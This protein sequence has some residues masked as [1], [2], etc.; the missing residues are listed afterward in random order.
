MGAALRPD[1][2]PI[3]APPPD[4]R[5]GVFETLL[6][7]DGEPVELEAHLER[8]A[9]STGELFGEEPPPGTPDLV[10]E[11]ARPLELG[12]LRLDLVPG[13]EGRLAATVKVAPVDAALVFPPWERAITL[14]AIVVHGGLGAHK[15]S[16]RRLLDQ[17]QRDCGEVLPLL[18]DGDGTVLEVSRGNVFLVRDGA[19]VTPVTDGRLLPGVARRRIVEAAGAAGFRVDEEVVSEDGLRD[20]DEVF[21]SGSV[22]GIE[23][24]REYESVRRWEEGPVTPVIARALRQLWLE[25]QNRD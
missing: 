23:P 18:L 9:S 6:V 25:T 4:P 11:H 3:E 1:G 22:R 13:E 12:R 14:A 17:A 21:V 5:R 15:W 16:D 2:A 24:V 20:A 10:R 19:L 8:L 7:A